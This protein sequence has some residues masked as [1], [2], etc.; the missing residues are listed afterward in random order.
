MIPGEEAMMTAD[1]LIIMM[2]VAGMTMNEDATTENATTRKI[3]MMIGQQDPRMAK[4]G[5]VDFVA[6]KRF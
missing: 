5:V 3:A 4:D 1:H 6:E 2:T